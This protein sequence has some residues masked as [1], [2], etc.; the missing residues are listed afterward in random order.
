MIAAAVAAKMLA[1]RI[2]DKKIQRVLLSFPMSLNLL[3]IMSV[4]E[5]LK[6][7]SRN[8]LNKIKAS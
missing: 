7:R 5:R 6:L 4:L 3:K 2:F 1:N 8:N